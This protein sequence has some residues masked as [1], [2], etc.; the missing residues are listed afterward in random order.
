M[1]QPLVSRR[2]R[3]TVRLRL[4]L[5]Y[6]GLLV[7]AGV[8]LSAILW[9]V[10][11]IV[12]NYP[13]MAANPRDQGP[14]PT[15]GEILDL[16]VTLSAYALVF[17]AIVGLLGGWFLAGRMLKPLQ[18]ITAA[19]QRAASGSLDH[20]I[21]LTGIRDEFTDLSDTFDAMLERLQRSFEQY[22]RFA[23]NASHE[24][25]TPH[26]VMKTMLDVAAADPD[27]Q[28]VPELV[29]R[30]AETNQRGIDIVEALL[31]LTALNN[32][33]VE[34]DAMDLAA[35]VRS[36]LPVLS[37]EAAEAGVVLTCDLAETVVEGNEVLLHQVVTN[38]VQNGIRH[39]GGSVGIT[40][41]GGR[42]VVRNDGVVLDPAQVRTFVEPFAKNRYGTGHGLGLALVSRIVE[43]HHGRLEL[44]A[45][46]AGGLTATVTLPEADLV[47]G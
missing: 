5:S 8:V 18:E 41:G 15:R 29:K 34:L 16:I 22:R 10:F 25:R 24:L 35:V 13:L 47:G 27:H 40:V 20:R 4:T 44:V 31:S 30:L 6:A 39:G 32:R 37:S 46:P 28:D 42:L 33:S 12:P 19:A 11:R 2:P 14:V 9:L 43:T 17:L 36:A 38:L 23:S 26:A 3:L 1:S 21:G 45:D 7:V